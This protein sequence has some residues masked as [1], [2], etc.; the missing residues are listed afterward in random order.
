[1]DNSLRVWI[2]RCRG[3]YDN[4][5]GKV[6][7]FAQGDT[8]FEVYLAGVERRVKKRSLPVFGD[9]PGFVIEKGYDRSK[10]NGLNHFL[11][12]V[13]IKKEKWVIDNKIHL[14]CKFEFK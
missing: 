14:Y 2:R 1:M 12:S 13:S 9:H 3:K 5:S 10:G 11:N 4:K 8:D 7:F 6:L